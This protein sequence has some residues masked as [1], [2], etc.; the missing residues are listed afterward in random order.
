MSPKQDLPSK[1]EE[2]IASLVGR[3]QA[4][5]RLYRIILKDFFGHVQK[6]IDVLEAKDFQLFFQ[7]LEKNYGYKRNTVRVYVNT[8]RSFLKSLGREDIRKQIRSV[9]PPKT[10]PSVLKPDEI[11]KMIN[12]ADTL[13]NKLIIQFLARTG[14]RVGE[15]CN[16]E[17]QDIDLQNLRLMV[18]EHGQWA[19]KGAKARGVKFDAQTAK[20]IK[21]HIASRKEGPLL[22]VKSG[23][24]RV[25]IK[26]VA[27]N[28]G[29]T[30]PERITPHR[31]RHFFA[32]DFLQRGGDIRSLQKLLG[33]ET[34]SVTQV[35]LDY[36]FDIVSDVYDRIYGGKSHNPINDPK[37]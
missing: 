34:L 14:L 20:L 33:H 5:K 32:C 29:V 15:L 30:N 28:A 4:T 26:K 23:T 35:Y 17:V 12:A 21:K 1:A 2:F 13:R 22:N 3:S 37:K 10:L 9:K 11:E 6:D 19:P 25:I 24:I 27:R 18:R 7:I 31:I 36:S 16:L 8:L